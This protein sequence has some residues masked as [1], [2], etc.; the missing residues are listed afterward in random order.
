MTSYDDKTGPNV[1]TF[2]KR[3]VAAFAAAALAVSLVACGASGSA[4]GG[5]PGAEVAGPVVAD[6]DI[7]SQLTFDHDAELQYATQFAITY[8]EDGFKLISLADGSRFLVVPEGVQTPTDLPDDIVVLQQPIDRIYLVGTATMDMFVAIDGLDSIRL[9]GTKAEDWY[10]DEAVAAMERGDIIYAGKYSAP[11]YELIVSEHCDLAVESTMI[12]HTP[13][14]KEQLE[15][16]GIPVFV[17]QSSYENH[18]LGR[19]EWV[20]VYG[21][22]L[23]KDD[24]AAAAFDAQVEVANS[25]E[26][27][28][29]ENLTVGFFY[30]NAS[31]QV[32][33]RK[34]SDY[35]PRMIEM[36]GGTYIFADLDDDT[37]RTSNV[38]M[39]MEEFY[40]GAKDADY[41]IY[42]STIEG[43]VMTLDDLIAKSDVLADFKAVQEGHVWC[44]EQSMYQESM[45]LAWF[46]KDVNLILNDPDIDDSELT[47]LYRLT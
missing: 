44:T 45:E 4:G 3:L 40:A 11:D 18:P 43:P 36:A 8:F 39:N 37:T 16:A 21:A 5:E 34:S 12:N 29:V 35:V 7:S 38:K 15:G 19:M 1:K 6:H 10:I 25:I 9:T 46:I 33:V 42:N 13:E 41:L 26:T 47:Y 20:K 14:V 32:V 30:I 31:G 2:A 17:D 27:E 22:M 24:E 23:N 28:D